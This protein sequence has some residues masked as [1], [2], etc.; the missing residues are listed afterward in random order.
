MAGAIVPLGAAALLFFVFA[1]SQAPEVHT[2]ASRGGA[3]LYMSGMRQL[4]GNVQIWKV[5]IMSG[6]RGTSQAGLRTFLPLYFVAA[7]MDDPFWLGVIVMVLQV[8]GAIA[9]PLRRRPVRP[10]RTQACPHGRL[11]WI[12]HYHLCTAID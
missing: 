3:K 2:P 1:S 8:G 6:F 7:F 4:V 5:L 10:D 12:M 11:R 9:T